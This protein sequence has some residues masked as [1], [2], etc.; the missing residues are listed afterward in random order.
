MQHT[1]EPTATIM[2]IYLRGAK[3]RSWT[4]KIINQINNKQIICV[5]EVN[6]FSVVCLVIN[7]Q[8]IVEF[9]DSIERSS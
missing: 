1:E 2:G 7:N 3:L 8:I 6:L 5:S 4:K 9:R